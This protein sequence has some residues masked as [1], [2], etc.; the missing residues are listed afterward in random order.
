[1][2]IRMVSE[3]FNIWTDRR[4]RSNAPPT[5]AVEK[6]MENESTLCLCWSISCYCDKAP[7]NN[8]LRAEIS[9]LAHGIRSF[10]QQW[11]EYIGFGSEWGWMSRQ[12]EQVERILTS[13]WQGNREQK[14]RQ[15]KRCTFL[16]QSR[17]YFPQ[18]GLPYYY[19]LALNNTPH[20]K[21][22]KGLITPLV[23]NPKNPVTSPES[24]TLQLSPKHTPDSHIVMA[25]SV[26]RQNSLAIGA[27]GPRIPDLD[28]DLLSC[29]SSSQALK[30]SHQGFLGLQFVDHRALY[31]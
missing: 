4:S 17:A 8:N 16:G 13:E 7:E 29:F 9:V 2:S 31:F 21:S 10:S 24:I 6:E 15:G 26:E 27:L 23:N 1:M 25:D 3:D 18:Q 22:I 14:T 28:F 19:S 12:W 30:P 11:A 20:Q 5:W